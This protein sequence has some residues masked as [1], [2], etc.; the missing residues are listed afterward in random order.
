[1]EW[2]NIRLTQL[3]APEYLRSDPTERATWLQLLAHCAG[4]ENGGTI[5]DCADWKDRVWQQIAGVTHREA[6]TQSRLWTWDKADLHVWGYPLEKEQIVKQKRTIAA[7]GGRQSGKAR[8]PAK[9]EPNAEAYASPNA[10]ANAE[11][12]QNQTLERKGREWERNGKEDIPPPLAQ[13]RP[14]PTGFPESEAKAREIAA[15]IGID[16]DLAATLWLELDAT[17]GT[18]DSG[19]VVTNFASYAKMRS[20]YRQS[21]QLQIKRQTTRPL[22]GEITGQITEGERKALYARYMASKEEAASIRRRTY[23]DDTARQTAATR[24]HELERLITDL[25]TKHGFTSK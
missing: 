5:K 12:D 16:P 10:Q 11:P 24:L 6:H 14:R 17:G 23:T 18:T 22:I 4:Q 13:A 25:E 19:Q 7:T 8:S 21:K 2:L 20:N 9:D 3:S 15:T 1:M